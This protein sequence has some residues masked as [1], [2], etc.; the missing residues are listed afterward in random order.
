MN[1]E[2]NNMLM[3]DVFE[4]INIDKIPNF[5]KKNVLKTKW[6]YTTKFNLNN[7]KIFK[8][9]LV[10]GGYNQIYGINYFDISSPTLNIDIIRLLICYALNNDY[11][12]HS[13]DINA[14]YLNA[15]IDTE[16]FI[17][18]PIGYKIGNNFILKLK[19]G[20]YGLKQSG[21]LWHQKFSNILKLLS[22]QHSIIE[23][24]VYFNKN[25][26]IILGVYVDDVIILGKTVK[27]I[28]TFVNELMKHL[29]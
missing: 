19:K 10:A 13:L 9:R 11:Q 5:D 7:Q 6:V 22:F 27:I 28:N 21:R 8:A 3:H 24:N 20:L 4:L 2:I 26:L 29:K 18:S 15:E 25:K 14:A 1:T 16:V 17:N 12:I 23:P